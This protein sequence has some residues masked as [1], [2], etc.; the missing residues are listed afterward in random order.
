MSVIFIYRDREP[1]EMAKEKQEQ[2][3]LYCNKIRLEK[4]NNSTT[5]TKNNSENKLWGYI[6]NK[7]FSNIFPEFNRKSRSNWNFNNIDGKI[8]LKNKNC[9]YHSRLNDKQKIQK[10]NNKFKV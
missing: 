1:F 9:V 10:Q 2:N 7:S 8:I 4:P 6:V 3:P 5:T